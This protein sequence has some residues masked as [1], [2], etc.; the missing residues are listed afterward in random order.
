MKLMV[1]TKKTFVPFFNGNRELPE[2]EQ[3]VVT[4]KVPDVELRN[5]LKPRPKFKYSFDPEGRTTGGEAEVALDKENVVSSMLVAL[6]HA[7]YEDEKGEHKIT[8]WSELIHA[9]KD[10][11]GLIDELYEEFRKELDTGVDEKN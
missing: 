1:S 10:F 9:P 5:R 7:E 4:Y 6:T 3:I 11:Q 8:K 2:E